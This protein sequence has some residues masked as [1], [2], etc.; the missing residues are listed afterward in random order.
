MGN[1]SSRKELLYLDSDGF[2]KL[3]EALEFL[4]IFNFGFQ[5]YS[6]F[7]N[8]QVFV[9]FIV[10]RFGFPFLILTTVH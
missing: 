3:K 9:R 6:V 4:L 10:I 1:L 2:F 8:F 7:S 5:M